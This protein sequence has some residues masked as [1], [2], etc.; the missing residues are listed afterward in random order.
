MRENRRSSP[1]L[2][3]AGSVTEALMEVITSASDHHPGWP[4]SHATQGYIYAISMPPSLVAGAVVGAWK[5]L[6][7]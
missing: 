2:P 5:C 3:P 4:G 7:R 6:M 1:S